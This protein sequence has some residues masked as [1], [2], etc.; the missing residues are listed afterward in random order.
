ML[1]FHR[2]LQIQISEQCDTEIADKKLFPRGMQNIGDFILHIFSTAQ[3]LMGMQLVRWESKKICRR[4]A[5]DSSEVPRA[6]YHRKASI[7]I[8]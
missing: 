8:L 6:F 4:T 5:K 7:V 2:N 3:R 1:Q